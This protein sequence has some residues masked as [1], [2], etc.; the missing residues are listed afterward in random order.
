[1]GG[2]IEDND[3][4]TWER[5]DTSVEHTIKPVDFTTYEIDFDKVKT[6]D[7]VNTILKAISFQFLNSHTAFDEFKHLLKRNESSGR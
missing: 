2:E 3:G 6:V 1:M 5:I 4:M 7:D